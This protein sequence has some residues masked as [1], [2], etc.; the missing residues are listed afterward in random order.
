M[1]VDP[2]FGIN[3]INLHFINDTYNVKLNC[4]PNS[5]NI[6][7]AICV[8]TF[9]NEGEYNLIYDN[10]KEINIQI[11]VNNSPKLISFVPVYFLPNEQQSIFF[12]FED[13]INSYKKRISLKDANNNNNPISCQNLNSNYSLNCSFY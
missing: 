11:L 12:Y 10:M 1:E 6:S 5:T 9:Y 4:E 8:G 7:K 3:Y 13:A 2:N